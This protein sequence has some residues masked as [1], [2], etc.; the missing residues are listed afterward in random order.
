MTAKAAP[1][2]SH[3]TINITDV[4]EK[5]T[6]NEGQERPPA[7]FAENTAANTRPSADVVG[8]TDPDDGD[9][10]DLLARRTDQGS[11]IRHRHIIR[12]VE[13]QGRTEQGNHRPSYTVTVSVHDGK[14]AAG[15][16]DTTVDNTITVTITV[17]DE[18]DSPEF[19]AASIT[20]A[21]RENTDVVESLG[22]PVTAT[23]GDNDTLTYSLD[24]AGAT[25][26][27][28]DS[29]S[30]QI[31]TKAG[32]TYD[33]EATPSYMI[34]VKADDNKGGTATKEVT[35]N[36]TDVDEPPLK[37]GKPAVLRTSNTAVSVTWTAPDNTGRPPILYYQYQYKKTS[38]TN[39]RKLLSSLGAV[40]PFLRAG[41]PPVTP[42][43][44]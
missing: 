31:K 26:F 12:P 18:N 21:V 35:V 7:T 29:T 8:A 2:L 41:L 3:V 38:N 16:T 32:V 40:I 37:P 1:T 42:S 34:T 11:S 43:A 24:T 19:R 13:D 10:L 4:N 20:R 23:D 25:S 28:I 30:G 36:V 27:D 17:T 6:F 44:H 33:H 9:T 5:P 22:N 39:T 15:S 14:N